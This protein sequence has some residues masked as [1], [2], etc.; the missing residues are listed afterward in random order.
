MGRWTWAAAASRG[1]SHER[2][3]TR[4]QDAHSCFQLRHPLDPF[5]AIVSDGAGSA[6][7]GGE[8]ASL[9][10]RSIGIRAREHFSRTIDR[11]PTNQ[12]IEEWLDATRDLLD[13]VA[14]RRTVATREFAAT[15]VCVVSDGRDSVIAHVGDGCAVLRSAATGTWSSP[16]WPDHGEYASTTYFV[17]DENLLK[18]RI[19]RHSEEISAV[20]VFSDGIERLVLDF[21]NQQPS[22][23]FFEQVIRPVAASQAGGRDALL[24][25]QL[26]AYLASASVNAR[27][28]DDKTLVLAVRR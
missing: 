1:T 22:Q 19:V 21:A 11:L 6:S 13:A 7:K 28:D 14:K 3:G 8:G 15:L 2:T 26:R 16:S 5:V 20:A 25:A 4:L 12:Q 23:A 24:S 17:T 9:I 18:L 27:T 10:C